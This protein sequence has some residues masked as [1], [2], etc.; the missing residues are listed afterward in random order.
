MNA[1]H[2]LALIERLAEHPL[3]NAAQVWFTHA[4]DEAPAPVILLS[5]DEDSPI[6]TLNGGTGL[7]TAQLSVDVWTH[8]TAEA[9]S[10]RQAALDQFEGYSAVLPAASA[11]ARISYL[12]SRGNTEDYD[13][14]ANM[15]HARA[16]FTLG[17]AD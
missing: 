2:R 4:P 13:A 6:S 15:A 1:P 5:L 17:Y 11:T 14:A 7:H 10:L 3:I 16:D 9:I 8:D 12:F